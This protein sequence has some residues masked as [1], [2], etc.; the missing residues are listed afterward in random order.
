MLVRERMY[1]NTKTYT[2]TPLQRARAYASIALN[3]AKRRMQC[4]DAWHSKSRSNCL[5]IRKGITSGES[6]YLCK[7][8]RLVCTSESE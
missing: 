7:Q 6:L 1:R 3:S 2:W 5:R 4:T 8:R